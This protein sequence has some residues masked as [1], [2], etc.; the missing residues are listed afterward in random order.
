MVLS[1]IKLGKEQLNVLACAD[2]I[3]LI[4]TNEIK[5]RFFFRNRKHCKKVRTTHKPIKNKIYDS[6]T[7]KQFKTK[8]NRT[9]SN[10]KLYILKS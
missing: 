7:E 10:K 8:Q 2:D 9:N 1:D 5:I 3:V 6:G 4:R